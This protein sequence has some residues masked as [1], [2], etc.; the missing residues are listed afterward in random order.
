MVEPSWLIP[1]LKSVP[2][3]LKDNEFGCSDLDYIVCYIID[4]G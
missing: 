3:H 4:D 2:I 1:Y